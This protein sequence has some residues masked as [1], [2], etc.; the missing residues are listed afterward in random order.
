LSVAGT[1]LFFDGRSVASLAN[2]AGAV[3]NGE[4][5]VAAG[6]ADLVLLDGQGN[7]IEKSPWEHPDPIEA[8]GIFPNGTVALATAGGVWAAD[9]QFLHWR[10]ISPNGAEPAWSVAV[11]APAEIH[12]TVA[13]QYRGRGLSLERL[14]L[15]LHSGRIFG[16]LGRLFFDVVAVAV[17]FL[18]VS[19]LIVWFRGRRNGNARRSG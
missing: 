10:P 9:E 14:L 17:G 4:I 8:I 11:P 5:L 3:T 1:Q 16:P 2:V 12:E 15:D 18:A 13:M 6:D 19:G 7:V